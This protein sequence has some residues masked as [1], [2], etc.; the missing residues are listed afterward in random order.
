[1]ASV[2]NEEGTEVGTKPCAQEADD[3]GSES[4]AEEVQQVREVV[5]DLVKKLGEKARALSCREFALIFS[6]STVHG[7]RRGFH[8]GIMLVATNKDFSCNLVD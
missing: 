2:K 3:P 1:M 7:K 6:E 8:Q 5:N 4:D